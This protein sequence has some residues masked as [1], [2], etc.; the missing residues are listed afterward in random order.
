MKES[1][2]DW[3]EAIV[4]AIALVDSANASLDRVTIEGKQFRVVGDRTTSYGWI[5]VF[6]EESQPSL[7]TELLKSR[8]GLT[9]REVQVAHLLAERYSNRE[10]AQQLGVTIFTAG[11]HTERILQKLRVSSRREVRAKL[12]E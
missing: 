2:H 4:A 12:L 1:M 3:R 10:I 11:R 5:F 9:E 8:F 7:C 6:V